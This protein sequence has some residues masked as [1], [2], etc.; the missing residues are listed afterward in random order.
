VISDF[1]S[2][3]DRSS[4]LGK[5][6]IDRGGDTSLADFGVVQ[7]RHGALVPVKPGSRPGKHAGG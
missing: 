2:I 1:F 7:L 6:S 4:V 5:Y 3:R